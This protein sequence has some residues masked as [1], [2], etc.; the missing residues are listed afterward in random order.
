M[1][2]APSRKKHLKK[3]V[4]RGQ[5]SIEAVSGFLHT[6]AAKCIKT[7]VFKVDEKYVFV[8]VRGDHEINDIKLKNYYQRLCC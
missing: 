3:F 1:K 7:L 2:K 6:E 8:L 4:H 5:K